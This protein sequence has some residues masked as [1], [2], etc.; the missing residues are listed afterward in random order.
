M[1][2]STIKYKGGVLIIGSLLWDKSEIRKNWRIQNLNT[3][4]KKLINLPIRYG[5][6][7][8]SRNCTYSM[9][10]SSECKSNEKIGKGYFLPFREELNIKEF[11]K[12]GKLLIDAE[13]N[14]ITKF[15]KFNWKWG[16]LAMSIN[17]NI[18]KEKAKTL[19]RHW[20]GKFSNDFKPS[21]YKVGQELSIVSR[22]GILDIDWDE[23]LKDIEFIIGTATKP[24][25][26]YPDASKIAIKMVVNEYDD[27]FKN[28]RKLSISTFQDEMIEKEMIKLIKNG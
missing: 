14:R 9:V 22:E 8:Q 7:S 24:E 5:R 19:R 13:H 17:P 15:E 16:C 6:I 26:I 20:L 12:Q 28:N 3:D 18:N 23:E 11:L 27:Y 25:I 2:D 21:Q 4:E 10:F 1:N